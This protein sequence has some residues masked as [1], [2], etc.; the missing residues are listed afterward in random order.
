MPNLHVAGERE[1]AQRE[2][3]QLDTPIV[4]EPARF[5][6]PEWSASGG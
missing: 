3:L 1:D 4:D 5:V 6:K 2:C